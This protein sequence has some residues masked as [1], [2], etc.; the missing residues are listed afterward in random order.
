MCKE[1]ETNFNKISSNKNKKKMNADAWDLEQGTSKTNS[2]IAS[3]YHESTFMVGI[4]FYRTAPVDSESTGGSSSSKTNTNPLARRDEP[5]S[6]WN[7]YVENPLI[8][9]FTK[10]M[11]Y[12]HCEIAFVKDLIQ[13]KLIP[14]GYVLAY[15]IIRDGFLFGKHRTFSSEQYEW[16]WISL[17]KKQCLDMQTFCVAQVGKSYDSSAAK[18]SAFWPKKIDSQQWYCTDFVVSALQQ[19]GIMLGKNP[20]A[21]T[22][23]DVYDVICQQGN[24]VQRASPFQRV[25]QERN[26][27]Q[28]INETDP[29]RVVHM[30]T[31]H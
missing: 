14:E 4:A 28:R 5:K 9:S 27:E 18:R 24:L 3:I 22:T 13:N 20:R 16:K 6:F 12:K 2:K 15:G 26:A 7:H 11:T 1:T 21:Q 8:R 29:N 31:R 17:P 10:N 25:K 30:E 23:D 19:G